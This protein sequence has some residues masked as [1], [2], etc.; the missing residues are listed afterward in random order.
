[1]LNICVLDIGG[2]SLKIWMP[3]APEA[4]KVETGKDFTPEDLVRE[5]KAVLGRAEIDRMS[6]GVPG[7]MRWGR[8]VEEPVNLGKGWLDFDFANAFG[9]PVRMLNDADMQAL[10]GYEGGRMLYLGL[11][12]GVGTTLIADGAISPVALGLLPFKDGKKFEDFLTKKALE[13]IGLRA[14]RT[15]VAKA[16]D[17]MRQATL[18]DYV[19]LGGSGAE[20]FETLPEWCRRGGNTNAYF[21]G[22]RM[23]EDI[24]VR[25]AM[26]GRAF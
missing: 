15:A 12:T 18:A 11:G 13:R 1:M 5:V 16:A 21:G 25:A 14:W 20:R 22:L 26:L 8:P 3:M 2:T 24:G 6:I 10:G 9:V 4:V 7:S 17:L 23:W 19:M